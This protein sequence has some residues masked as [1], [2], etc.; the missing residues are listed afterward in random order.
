MTST[1][2]GNKLTR[3]AAMLALAKGLAFALAFPLPLVLVRGLSQTDF[4]VYKQFSQVMLTMLG[5][6]SLHVGW[7]AFFFFPRYPDKKPQI[8]MNVM[9][10]YLALGLPV[11]LLFA[12]YPRVVTLVFKSDA[13][14][15]FVP[16][17]GFAILFWLVSAFLETVT[18]AD[19][20]TRTASVFI[21]ALQLIKSALLMVSAVVFAEL[22]A[23]LWAVV[24]HAGLQCV[25][26]FWYLR[27]RYGSFW[28]A[29]DW[30]LLKSQLAN[31]L[32]FG[33]GGIVYATQVDLHNYF[34]GHYFEPAEF[35]IYAVGCFQLPV[36]TLLLESVSSVLMPE[37]ARLQVE[38]DRTAIVSLWAA[39]VRKLALFFVPA[40]A[41][42]FVMRHEFIVALF[43]KAYEGAVPVFSVSLA[44]ILLTMALTN[45]MLRSF[46]QF[47]YFRLKLY[48]VLLPLTCAALYAGIHLAGMLGAIIAVVAI[49]S[50]DLTITVSV[51]GRHLGVPA[52]ELRRLSPILRVA[53]AAG[54]AALASF[55]VRPAFAS[56]RPLVSLAAGAA[57]FGLVYLAV[58]LATGAINASE[59]VALIEFYRSGAR[60]LGFSPATKSPVIES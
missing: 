22:G 34:V 17:L 19:R 15:P 10:F 30:P 39:A 40:C 49:Q 58:A 45:P 55:A 14:V 5:L 4:G 47:R 60:R 50:L 35:A 29:F 52:R 36:L 41:F 1:V 43:T 25:A 31:A 21:V 37:V 53:G 16:L 33:V 32:P 11:A 8:V 20:D 6:L 38:G 3:R 7:T 23:V 13:L 46:D 2:E 48:A 54:V 18:V 27:R 26:L 9:A 57:I 56:L 51:I 28:R 59:R 24:I 42:L 12:V 44:G